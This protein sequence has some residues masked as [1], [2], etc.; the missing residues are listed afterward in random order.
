[1]GREVCQE[2]LMV[3]G[4]SRDLQQARPGNQGLQ[5]AKANTRAVRPP[6]FGAHGISWDP[7]QPCLCVQGLR[8]LDAS[9]ENDGL[10]QPRFS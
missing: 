8:R 6:S 2:L 1:M 7:Q 9:H 5:G 10:M 3:H 4:V